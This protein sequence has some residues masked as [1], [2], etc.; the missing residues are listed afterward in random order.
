MAPFNPPP[1]VYQYQGDDS[2]FTEESPDIYLVRQ[3]SRCHFI[4]MTGKENIAKRVITGRQFS[5]R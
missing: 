2:C 4:H 3:N 5:N 1:S